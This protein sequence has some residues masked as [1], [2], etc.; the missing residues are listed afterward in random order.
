VCGG[1]AGSCTVTRFALAESRYADLARSFSSCEPRAPR[2]R[3]P[4]GT[5]RGLSS[6]AGRD[7]PHVVA[8]VNRRCPGDPRF[9]ALGARPPHRCHEP[10]PDEDQGRVRS[11]G[12]IRP[13]LRRVLAHEAI[14]PAIAATD[15][16]A[17]S[18]LARRV[19]M[20]SATRPAS[21]L[22]PPMSIDV[23]ECRKSSPTK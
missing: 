2:D 6:C 11:F 17:A 20:C 16:A 23:N 5:R 15:V 22:D 4:S 9:P 10:V 3:Q 12:T 14:C 19:A 1:A 21:L 7:L 18:V 8:R 13:S